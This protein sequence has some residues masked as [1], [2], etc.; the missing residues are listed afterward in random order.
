MPINFTSKANINN[1]LRVFLDIETIPP[2]EDV[3]KQILQ[4]LIGRTDCKDKEAP[5]KLTE[6]ADKQ[7]RDLALEPERGQILAI[8]VIVNR[9]AETLCRRV[10]GWDKQTERF[11]LD[12][13]RTLSEFWD[14]IE[15]SQ[16]KSSQ[17][18][19]VGHNI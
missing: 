17:D 16:F 13:K 8:G 19:I 2:S 9:G 11:H 14:K 1:Q 18:V 7:F 3:R 10:F 4:E 12:E 5:W 15:K 6:I